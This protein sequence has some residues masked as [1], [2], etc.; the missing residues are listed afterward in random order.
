V[1]KPV[2]A[3]YATDDE[4]SWALSEWIES[5]EFDPPAGDWR[6]VM[7]PD[8]HC[9]DPTC[10]YHALPAG[11]RVEVTLALW[12]REVALADFLAAEPDEL[13]HPELR[14]LRLAVAQLT[15]A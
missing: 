2:R 7:P 15:D 12:R 9:G 10:L 5:D 1:K 14:R 8:E 6:R 3:D 11:L 13:E 4:W